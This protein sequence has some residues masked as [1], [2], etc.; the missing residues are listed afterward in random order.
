MQ[1]VH[2]IEMEMHDKDLNIDATKLRHDLLVKE[3]ASGAEGPAASY[4][5]QGRSTL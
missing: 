4:Q 1:L 5:S 3:S 2:Q